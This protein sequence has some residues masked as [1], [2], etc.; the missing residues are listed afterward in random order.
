MRSFFNSLRAYCTPYWYWLYFPLSFFWCQHTPKPVF[1]AQPSWVSSMVATD[2]E[3]YSDPIYSTAAIDYSANVI[4]HEGSALKNFFEQLGLLENKKDRKVR[5]LHIGDSHIQADFFSGE[6]RKR[7]QADPRFG[8]GGRGFVFPYAAAKTNNPFNYQV[9]TKGNWEP[10]RSI[11]KNA[12]SRWGLSGLNAITMEVNSEISLKLVPYN[13]YQAPSFSHVRIFYPI[14]DPQ[15]YEVTLPNQTDLIESAYASPY[16]YMAFDLKSPQ[17]SLDIGLKKTDKRQNRFLMQGILLENNKAGI[18]YNATGLNGAE[19]NTYFRCED[20]DK[21]VRSIA[22]NLIIISLGTNDA[23]VAKFD[24]ALYKANLKYMI[25]KI[26]QIMPKVS[27]L[28]T[29]PNDSYYMGQKPN[30]NTQEVVEK[31]EEVSR[32]MRVAFWDFYT[33]MGGLGTVKRWVKQGLAQK[34]L[35]HLTDRGYQLQGRL[36]HKALDDAY[37]LSKSK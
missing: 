33:V 2:P 25:N 1:V 21:H 19:V 34:D 23:N 20:F 22:P 9:S 36:L 31:L 11:S 12:F 26:R 29:S 14:E 30:K 4:Q 37:K 17:T 13:G 7:L 16:G 24:A 3:G 35:I 32:E 8:N 28:L 6:V 18:V 15:N 10:K 5:I 27:I